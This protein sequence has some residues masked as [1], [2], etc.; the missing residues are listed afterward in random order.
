MKEGDQKRQLVGN[1]SDEASAIAK[2]S[3]VVLASKEMTDNRLK[4]A[5]PGRK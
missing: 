3:V 5:T 4:K 1:P 2:A